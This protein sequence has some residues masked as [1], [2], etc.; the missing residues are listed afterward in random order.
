M[1]VD[2]ILLVHGHS[3]TSLDASDLP[4]ILSSKAVSQIVLSAFNSLDDD[5]SIDDLAL[6]L[7]EHAQ[8]VEAQGWKS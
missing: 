7:E 2:H 6:A 1:G 8:D 5:V 3:E 4:R